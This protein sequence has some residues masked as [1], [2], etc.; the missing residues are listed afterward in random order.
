[1]CT[2]NAHHL[3]AVCKPDMQGFLLTRCQQVQLYSVPSGFEAIQYLS[4]C[5]AQTQR[6]NA[7]PMVKAKNIHKATH[8]FAAI[9]SSWLTKSLFLSSQVFFQ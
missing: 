6:Q 7:T 9:L 3:I 2:F 1:M 4:L 8:L 5:W